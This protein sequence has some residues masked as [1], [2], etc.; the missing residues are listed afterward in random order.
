[1]TYHISWAVRKTVLLS[2]FDGVITREELAQFVAEIRGKV[3]EANR[4][5]YHISD[6]LGLT[7]VELSVRGLKDLVGSLS[8]FHELAWQVD[9]NRNTVN[10]MLASITTQIVGVRVRTVPTLEE[11]AIF[12]KTVNPALANMV[13]SLPDSTLPTS[14]KDPTRL[15]GAKSDERD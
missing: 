2:T 3:T 15:P 12:L 6:S 4:P 14:A 7:R 13:W 9:V 8:L 1:M 11:A 10:K 5:C